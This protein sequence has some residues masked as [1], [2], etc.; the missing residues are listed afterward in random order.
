MT[1]WHEGLLAQKVL[2]GRTTGDCHHPQ[3]DRARSCPDAVAAIVSY[4]HAL[5]DEADT[6][7]YHFG[8]AR[9]PG[10]VTPVEPID[11]TTGQL[12]LE[13]AHPC[14]KVAARAREWLPRVGVARA[15]PSFRV[16][17]GPGEP[18]ERAGHVGN[19]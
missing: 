6:R 1:C 7:G 13:L 19:D 5:A 12:D 9:I 11:V 3:V 16:L 2:Q 10:P 18:W 17:H 8:R 4:L 14:A 15:H